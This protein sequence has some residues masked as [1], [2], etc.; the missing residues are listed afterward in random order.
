MLKVLKVPAQ[1]RG[2]RRRRGVARRASRQGA[3]L[4]GLGFLG[5]EFRVE[6]L[7]LGAYDLVGVES[8]PLATSG[9]LSTGQ[10]PMSAY[11]GSSKNLKDL[12]GYWHQHGC[13]ACIP[14]KATGVQGLL[15]IQ[16][17]HRRRVLQKS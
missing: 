4:P 10:F 15:E 12:K 13:H 16:D 14:V 11:V 9:G 17:T 2:G 3:G 5:L 7:G 8:D 1:S 6:G